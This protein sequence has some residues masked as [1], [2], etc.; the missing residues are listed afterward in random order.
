MR[1][2]LLFRVSCRCH[3]LC[4]RHVEEFN[5]FTTRS[6]KCGKWPLAFQRT[7]G[8]D[9]VISQ[10]CNIPLTALPAG[11][12]QQD[13]CHL[14][15]PDLVR[16]SEQRTGR[17]HRQYTEILRLNVLKPRRR[18]KDSF[19]NQ[20][21]TPPRCVCSAAISK[22]S[23]TATASRER[24]LSSSPTST[25][26]LREVLSSRPAL[27]TGVPAATT[28]IGEICYLAAFRLQAVMSVTTSTDS[29]AAKTRTR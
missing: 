17:A 19:S 12:P 18:D 16:F 1:T 25:A 3:P 11:F 29:A 28:K 27:A 14:C 6:L 4:W 21:I 2:H 23:Q 24:I 15:I 5:G 8:V 20:G 10:R 26:R 13:K 22:N 7:I 9:A